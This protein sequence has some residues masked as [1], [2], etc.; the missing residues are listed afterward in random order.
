MEGVIFDFNGTLIL[1]DCINII[2]WKKYAKRALNYDLTDEEYHKYNGTPGEAWITGITK[3]KIVGEEAK[4]HRIAKEQ[5]YRDDLRDADIDL[6][7]GARDLFNKLIEK[8]I[9]FTIA[10]S[11]DQA[12]VELYFEKFKLYKW[13]D[14]RKCMFTDG[15]FKGKP[16]PEIYLNAAKKIGVDINK[17]VVF[18][19]TKSGVR[20]GYSAGAKVVGMTAGRP[21]EEIWK[22]EK[23][24]KVI[25]DFTQVTIEDLNELFTKNEKKEE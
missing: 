24:V 21:A 7:K 3:G 10:T 6:V 11:S 4:K 19:D 13:F 25:D 5:Q 16:S 18:E 17:C 15:T 8:N 20:S 22:F 9:P 1:D 2:S 23:V 12:N 14:F